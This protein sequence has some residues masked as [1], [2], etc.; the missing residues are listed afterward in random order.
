MSKN[1]CYNCNGE[2]KKLIRNEEV[3][4]EGRNV[5]IKN[6]PILRCECGEEFLECDVMK[7]INKALLKIDGETTE[8]DYNALV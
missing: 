5:A 8:I 6:T 3:I 7:K 4:I 1:T 2:L